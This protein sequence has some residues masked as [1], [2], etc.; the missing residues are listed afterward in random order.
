MNHQETPAFRP[1]TLLIPVV[2][3]SSA[4]LDAHESMIEEI[5]SDL[6]ARLELGVPQESLT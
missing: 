2:A 6:V 3:N 1:S 4:R 5:N